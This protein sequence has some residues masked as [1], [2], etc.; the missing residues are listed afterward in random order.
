[1]ESEILLCLFSSTNQPRL[2]QVS[3]QAPIFLTR[4]AEI[5][6]SALWPHK[7][8]CLKLGSKYESISE[9]LSCTNIKCYYDINKTYLV[10]EKSKSVLSQFLKIPHKELAQ[11]NR[12]KNT[13]LSL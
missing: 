2:K 13:T 11:A 10:K 7:V 1:M 4:E 8:V 3:L 5:T 9:L 6:I 12:T